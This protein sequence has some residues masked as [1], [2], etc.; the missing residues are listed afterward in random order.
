MLKDITL[1]QYYPT[2]SIIHRLDPRVKLLA[3][4][5][6]LVSLFLFH[7]FVGFVVVT[8]F[9][10]VIIKLSRVPF[11]FMLKGVRAIW[12]LVVITA[13]CNLFFTQG[14][15]TYFA[16]KFIHITDQGVSNTVYFTIRLIYLVVGTSVMTLTTTPNKL[17]DGLEEGLKPLSKIGVPVHEIAMMMSIAMRFIRFWQR[18]RIRS[19]KHR[20][21]EA[22]I[23]KRVISFREP[24]RWCRSW[25]RCLYLH[26]DV[27]MIWRR[28]WKRA[29]ITVVRA[30]PR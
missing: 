13:V 16:W 4:L 29:V 20:W 5:M 2:E 10:L 23:L 9:L 3:T 28:L 25:C 8:L 11:S 21:Q 19:K 17:T 26:S 27:P 18:K 22:R 30:E 1:G 6:Y 24:K 12:V 15:N 7:D 14:D